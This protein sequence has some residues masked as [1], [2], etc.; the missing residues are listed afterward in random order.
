MNE[1]YSVDY[2]IQKF[3]TIPDRQWHVGG[4]DGPNN[5]HCAA[6]HCGWKA[7][8]Y[9]PVAVALY[10]LFKS[11]KASVAYVNDGLDVRFQQPTPKARILAAL[12]AI[13]AKQD[14]AKPKP[15]AQPLTLEPSWP[16]VGMVVKEPV[17]S[18]NEPGAVKEPVS[19]FAETK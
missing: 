1:Q 9:N 19:F 16:R 7:N 3:E 13:K 15:T 12:Y 17:K 8:A 14:A 4:F 6:G 2:F 18:R 11:I 10:A 5:S